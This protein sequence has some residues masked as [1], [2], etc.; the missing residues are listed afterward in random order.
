MAGAQSG[1]GYLVSD[2]R[3]SLETDLLMA[4][5]LVI[6]I[7]GLVLDILMRYGEEQA[8]KIWGFETTQGGGN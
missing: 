8:G 6:G 5:I 1:L 4:A 2:A 3:N 7:L